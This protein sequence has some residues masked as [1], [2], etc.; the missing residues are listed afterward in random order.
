L[1]R[2]SSAIAGGWL[3]INETAMTDAPVPYLAAYAPL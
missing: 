1:P 2:N 3:A